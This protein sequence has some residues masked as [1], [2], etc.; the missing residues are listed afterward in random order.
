MIEKGVLGHGGIFPG[1]LAQTGGCGFDGAAG[2]K[3]E[4]RKESCPEGADKKKTESSFAE[5]AKGCDM[6]FLFD[7]DAASPP[8]KH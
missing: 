8:G 7:E 6:D 4:K 1:P 5:T 2:E 3:R